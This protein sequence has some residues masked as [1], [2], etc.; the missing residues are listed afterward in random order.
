[1]N[2]LHIMTQEEVFFP[3]KLSQAER[4]VAGMEG[5]ICFIKKERKKQK[6]DQEEMSRVLYF[7][8]IQEHHL[9]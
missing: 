3:P 8:S 5:A 1:M 7:I 9:L 6:I 2:F 4:I